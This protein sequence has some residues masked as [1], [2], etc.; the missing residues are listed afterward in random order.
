MGEKKAS[1]KRIAT[2]AVVHIYTGIEPV[3]IFTHV[4]GVERRGAWRANRVIV[5][6]V[7]MCDST[8]AYTQTCPVPV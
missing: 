6:V 5:V 1:M 2:R 7:A 3:H 4:Y 8:L